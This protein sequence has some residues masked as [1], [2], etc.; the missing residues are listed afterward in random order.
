[1]TGRHNIVT[2]RWN[3]SVL[4]IVIPRG[5]DHVEEHGA[6][7]VLHGDTV[8]QGILSGHGIVLLPAIQSDHALLDGPPSDRVGLVPVVQHTL[9]VDSGVLP[10]GEPQGALVRDGEPDL[11]VAGRW[12][13]DE[14]PVPCVVEW[15]QV[16]FGRG[17]G[18]QH[19]EGLRV[20]EDG[21]DQ[22]GKG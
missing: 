16:H 22:G 11:L 4:L 8:L 20:G 13:P 12:G 18:G 10:V 5:A 14:Q 2:S 21:S 6:L 19:A 1:M 3:K 17:V 7:D 9:C 15:Q